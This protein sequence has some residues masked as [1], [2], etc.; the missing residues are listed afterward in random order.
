MKR[1]FALLAALLLWP[2]IVWAA[3]RYPARQEA[4]SDAAAVLSAQ[5]VADLRTL[6][7][8]LEDEDA[9]SIFVVTVDFLDGEG[10]EDYAAGLRDAWKLGR[11]DLLLL[12]AVGEDK[13]TLTG[14]ERVDERLSASTRRKLLAANFEAPFLRQDY[15]GA[16]AAFMPALVREINKAWN[17]DVRVKGLFGVQASVPATERDWLDRAERWEESIRRA[18]EEDDEDTFTVGHLF[19]T[20]VLLAIIFSNF[21]RRDQR[22][23]R[24]CGCGCMP[25]SSLLA[26]L[27][28]WKLWQKK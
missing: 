2:S 11:N 10:I 6:A 27:G 8:A 23:R 25:F 9:P 18:G 5:T 7:D 28:L 12:M 24:G 19:L 17:C 26:G 16:I 15:D 13:F 4:V 22:Y 21:N 20:F 1:F 3:P 14:G